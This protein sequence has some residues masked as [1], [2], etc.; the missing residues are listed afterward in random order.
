VINRYAD[1]SITGPT[2]ATAVSCTVDAVGAG[3][4][5]GARVAVP[6]GLDTRLI[7]RWLGKPAT[8]MTGSNRTTLFE[9]QKRPR[10]RPCDPD[11]S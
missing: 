5:D 6:V 11:L 4:V 1:A 2:A 8:V 7:K 10:K 9:G 3:A